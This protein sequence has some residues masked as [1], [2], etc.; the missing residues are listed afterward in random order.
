MEWKDALKERQNIVL[1]TS[2]KEG[3]PRAIVVVSL[4]F[5]DDRLLIGA[6]PMGKSLENIRENNKVSIATFENNA[7][8]RID[9]IATIYAEGKYLET[10]VRKSNP[11]LPKGAIVVDIKEVF[12]L[13][14]REKIL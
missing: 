6:C 9:G 14:K 11:P 3:S 10:A 2:S 13:D 1:A 12:D 7:Y 5:V 8:Y 4:G